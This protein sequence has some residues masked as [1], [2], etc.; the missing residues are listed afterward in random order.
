MASAER[1]AVVQIPQP[2]RVS[3]RLGGAASAPDF[4]ELVGLITTTIAPDSWQEIGGN[5][6][7]RE[8]G[9]TLSLVVRQTQ[10]VHEEI[11]DLLDQLRRLQDLQVTIELRFVTVSDRF[12]ERIGVD[13]NFNLQPTISGPD[14]D[15]N[16]L[17]LLPFGSVVCRRPASWDRPQTRAAAS[18]AV[19]WAVSSVVS[20]ASRLRPA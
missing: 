5:G 8:H 4:S 18:W 11:A 10:R 13:F 17:P 6:T 12:F 7:I 20:R 16:N 19:S 2:Y 9:T 14:V 1:W 15:N 3:N